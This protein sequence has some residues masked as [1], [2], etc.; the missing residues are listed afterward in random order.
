MGFAT[1][2]PPATLS[3]LDGSFLRGELV[4]VQ[5]GALVWRHANARQPI[6][7]STTNLNQVQLPARLSATATNATPLCRLRLAGGDELEGQLMSLDAETFE[8]ET[9]F[10]GRLRGQRAGLASLTFFGTNQGSLYEGPRAADEWKV[11]STVNFIK[12]LDGGN[13][14]LNG[15]RANVRARHCTGRGRSRPQIVHRSRSHQVDRSRRAGH[16]RRGVSQVRPRRY[17]TRREADV[18][19]DAGPMVRG[20]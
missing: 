14:F 16:D 10:A 19:R 17:G 2:L 6:E 15:L 1:N 5:G 7:F 3:F 8:L 20:V 12:R 11:G 13:I 4:S 9:W 18:T